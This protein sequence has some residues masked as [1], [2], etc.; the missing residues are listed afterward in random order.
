MAIKNQVISIF[1]IA[2]FEE[3]NCTLI[4]SQLKDDQYFYFSIPF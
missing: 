1:N 3:N 2:L 4:A